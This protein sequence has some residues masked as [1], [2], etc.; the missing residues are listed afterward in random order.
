MTEQDSS[1]Q[2]WAILELMG[3]RRLAGRVREATIAG[4]AFIRIDIPHP[5]DSARVIATQFYS[6]AALYALTPSTA[7][8]ACTIAAQA[9]QPVT[10]WDLCALDAP[11]DSDPND[12]PEFHDQPF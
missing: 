5:N 8:I 9:P 6:P 12:D 11:H 3:H 1:F 4:A 7:E 10:R 2:G